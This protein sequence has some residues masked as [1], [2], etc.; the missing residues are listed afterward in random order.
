MAGTRGI[1][2]A[3]VLLTMMVAGCAGSTEYAPLAPPAVPAV[4]T[5]TG[6]LHLL[7][8]G[9]L[10]TASPAGVMAPLEVVSVQ[11]TTG[12]PSKGGDTIWTFTWPED[13]QMVKGSASLIV[14][15]EGVVLNEEAAADQLACFWALMV[16]VMDGDAQTK[17]GGLSMSCVDEPMVVTPG[18]KTLQVPLDFRPGEFRQGLTAQVSLFHYGTMGPGAKVELLTGSPDQDSTVTFDEL[19]WPIGLAD[20]E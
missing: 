2:S 18:V 19:A 1:T 10:S 4:A 11:G 20:I 12:N 17:E 9:K 3:A 6:T 16:T 13:R 14:S 8:D 7:A 15:V 5:T